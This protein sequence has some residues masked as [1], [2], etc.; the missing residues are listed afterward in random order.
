MFDSGIHAERTL[1]VIREDQLDIKASL[2]VWIDGPK[3]TKD[4]KNQADIARGVMLANEYKDIIIGVSVG[5]EVLDDWSSVHT[6]PA[7]LAE[8]IKQVREQVTQPVTTDD[9]YPPY[10]FGGGYGDVI[11]VVEQIDYVSLHVYAFIDAQ[12]SWDWKQERYPIGPERAAAMMAAAMDFTK[13]AV[14]GVKM[15]HMARGIELPIVIGEAGWKSAPT[16]PGESGE[17]FRAHPLNQQQYYRAFM[18]WVA[19]PDRDVRS[20]EAAHWFEAF[21]EPWKGPD[22]GWGLFDS[23]RKPKFAVSCSYP[24]LVPSGPTEYAPTDA[25]FFQ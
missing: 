20:P 23:E 18:S 8:Y 17:Q 13:E 6:P 22:D 7:D 24:E 3:E 14:Y 25:I 5:N 9:M 2:G 4:A 1:Q 12:W 19:G 21:D 16:K 15:S 11:K 10:G